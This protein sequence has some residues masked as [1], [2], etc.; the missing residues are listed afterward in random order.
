MSEFVNLLASNSEFTHE[1]FAYNFNQITYVKLNLKQ[2]WLKHGLIPSNANNIY[3]FSSNQSRFDF[4][5]YANLNLNLFFQTKTTQKHCILS[6]RPH[7]QNKTWFE[8]SLIIKERFY[9]DKALHFDLQGT[10]TW[11]VEN[12]NCRNSKTP[13]SSDAE[14]S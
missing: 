5:P 13:I 10:K 11:R 12:K 14:G 6:P 3:F 9:L 2:P 4:N 7:T 8:Y 1:N